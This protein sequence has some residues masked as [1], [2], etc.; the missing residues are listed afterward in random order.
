[1]REN[2]AGWSGDVNDRENQLPFNWTDVAQHSAV[3]SKRNPVYLSSSEAKR[4]G[5]AVAFHEALYL[6]QP[7]EDFGIQ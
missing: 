5:M 3:V 6:K 7:Q 1:M 2:Y 4:Q